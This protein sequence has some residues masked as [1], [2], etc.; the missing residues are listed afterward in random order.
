MSTTN[1]V[2]SPRENE[3]GENSFGRFGMKTL[4]GPNGITKSIKVK[5]IF[6]IVTRKMVLCW[7]M[8]WQKTVV[9]GRTCLLSPSVVTRI[10]MSKFLGNCWPFS[11]TAPRAAQKVPAFDLLPWPLYKMS[12]P[13]PPLPP[14]S[15][16]DASAPPMMLL[17]AAAMQGDTT[18]S[19][20]DGSRTARPMHGHFPSCHQ[21]VERLKKLRKRLADMDLV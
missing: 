11:T 1:Y 5:E 14:W 20:S 7:V 3:P 13:V 16:D 10:N 18:A 6:G 17:C 12:K 21:P 15:L 9:A 2:K 4:K 8:S 19:G